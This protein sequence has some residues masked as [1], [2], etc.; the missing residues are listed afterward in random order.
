MN[1]AINLMPGAVMPGTATV[2]TGAQPGLTANTGDALGAVFQELLVQALGTTDPQTAAVVSRAGQ[3]SPEESAEPEAP[4]EDNGNL[5]KSTETAPSTLGAAQAVTATPEFVPVVEPQTQVQATEPASE[6][7]A[8]AVEAVVAEGVATP[9]EAA[10]TTPV[11]D[12]VSAVEPAAV[13]VEAQTAQ[14]VVDSTP[15]AQPASMAETPQTPVEASET[16]D[17]KAPQAKDPREAHHARDTHHAS[18]TYPKN[19]AVRTAE[20]ST[21]ESSLPES[22]APV[23]S[24]S[25]SDYTR[26]RLQMK[27]DVEVKPHDQA[28]SKEIA[29]FVAAKPD[30]KTVA[31]ATD[32]PAPQEKV[33]I[34]KSA[35]VIQTAGASADAA[36]PVRAKDPMESGTQDAPQQQKDSGPTWAVSDARPSFERSVEGAQNSQGFHAPERVI[37][38]KVIRQIVQSARIQMV[39]G[40]ANMTLRLDPPHLG[41]LNMSVSTQDGSV[42]AHIQTS[43]E[44]ARHVLQ[45]DLPTLKQALSDAGIV[46]DSI[47]V[48]LNSTLGQ[49]STPHGGHHAHRRNHGG[50]VGPHFG[51]ESLSAGSEPSVSESR[52][53]YGAGLFDYLA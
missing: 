7:A 17:V 50:H 42:V 24:D 8:V 31:T 32:D 14:P 35:V 51:Q 27:P 26:L 10:Q 53:V 38:Q 44:S 20:G 40:G 19:Q 33:V 15:D 52:T 1:E 45:A 25:T 34:G 28:R 12:T 16:A 41:T 18:E 11:E 9:S 5:L 47:N 36:T 13:T 49:S 48:S 2:T 3:Q 4:A 46:V 39:D 30:T 37:E 43:T 23:T 21:G 29:G 6:V 22:P